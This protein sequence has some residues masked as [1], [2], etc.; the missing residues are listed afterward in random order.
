MFM[1]IYLI[2]ISIYL[3]HVSCLRRW[4][5]YLY[6]SRYGYVLLQV[7][8]ESA[9][10]CVVVPCECLCYCLLVDHAFELVERASVRTLRP[11][12]R[13][14]MAVTPSISLLLCFSRLPPNFDR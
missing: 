14:A 9:V 8:R 11:Q 13:L 3:V 2:S 10:M 12:A 5:T 1:T 4:S 7:I 6:L